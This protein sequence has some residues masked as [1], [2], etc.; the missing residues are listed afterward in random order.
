MLYICKGD[1]AT[2]KQ[3]TYRRTGTSTVPVFS[4]SYLAIVFTW[5]LVVVTTCYHSVPK[6]SLVCLGYFW[7]VP[8]NP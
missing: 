6:K 2:E 7:I 1:T 5:I 3:L 8:A 4:C